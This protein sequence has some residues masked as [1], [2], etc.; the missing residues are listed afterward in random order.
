MAEF[1]DFYTNAI[2][3]INQTLNEGWEEKDAAKEWVDG[4]DL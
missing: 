4:L 2:S 1:T 3:F